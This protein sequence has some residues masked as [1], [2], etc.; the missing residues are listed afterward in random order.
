MMIHY[1]NGQ[2]FLILRRDLGLY[3]LVVVEVVIVEQNYRI[4]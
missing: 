4:V 3:V 1:E 2:S